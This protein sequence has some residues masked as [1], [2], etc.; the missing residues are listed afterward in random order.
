M[1]GNQGR[2]ILFG[3][4]LR[5]INIPGFERATAV[6]FKSWVRMTKRIVKVFKRDC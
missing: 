5:M 2:N 1:N 3:L 4:H 6:F